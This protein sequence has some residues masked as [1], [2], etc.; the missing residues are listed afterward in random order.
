[1]YLKHASVMN[2]NSGV[3]NIFFLVITSSFEVL[4]NY[5]EIHHSSPSSC[6]GSAIIKGL[7]PTH[8]FS[9]NEKR[10]SS[11]C[12][13]NFFSLMELAGLWVSNSSLLYAVS[14]LMFIVLM[15]STS[16]YL[17]VFSLPAGLLPPFLRWPSSWSAHTNLTF[18]FHN[19]LNTVSKPP[20][21]TYSLVSYFPIFHVPYISAFSS[22]CS[23]S[24]Q[25]L[26]VGHFSTVF[27]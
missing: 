20:L 21:I 3:I 1:M 23:L 13:M 14:A 22:H 8:S 27:H 24:Y 17:Q 9:C 7:F 16:H 18:C 4:Q 5:Q 26:F 10:Q 15:P 11:F 12:L 19:T 2:N 6:K 25:A